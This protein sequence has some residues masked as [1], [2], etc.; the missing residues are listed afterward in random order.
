MFDSQ[1]EIVKESLGLQFKEILE[2]VKDELIL[3]K[4]SIEQEICTDKDIHSLKSSSGSLGSVVVFVE[5]EKYLS[6]E[7]TNLKE[8]IEDCIKLKKWKNLRREIEIT[9]HLKHKNI[10]ETYGY[11]IHNDTMY[12]I[13]EYAPRGT[14]FEVR[15][16]FKE[17][18]IKV[19]AN[20]LLQ[21]LNYL[22]K[23]HIIHRD[24]KLENTFI[25]P[26]G[27]VKIGD[28]DHSIN[29]KKEIAVVGT[30]D[31]ISPETIIFNANTF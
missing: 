13:M 23:N 10:L 11:F 30:T 6:K 24:I 2:M 3:V 28:F 5:C 26:D 18:E 19:I 20:Q 16:V 9:L 17:D 7:K 4:K 29:Y 21:G 1:F 25:F 31:Y 8:V 27:R 22:H 12:C 14:L 15:T